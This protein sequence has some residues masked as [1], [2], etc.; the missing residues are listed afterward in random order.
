MTGTGELT[1]QQG[2]TPNG[3]P[4]TGFTGQETRDGGTPAVILYQ[5]AGAVDGQ[6]NF[7]RIGVSAQG[8]L[9]EGGKFESGELTANTVQTSADGEVDGDGVADSVYTFSHQSAAPGSQP[10][11]RFIETRFQS[12]VTRT[13]KPAGRTS[14][15]AR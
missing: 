11:L 12:Y 6:G 15:Q 13:A 14:S 4:S 10:P 3:T 9:I 5:F 8:F 2:R 1:I 7:V